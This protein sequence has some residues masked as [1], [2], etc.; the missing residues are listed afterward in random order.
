MLGVE[1]LKV[2]EPK[3]KSWSGTDSKV[4]RWRECA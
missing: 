1:T 2:R 3:L 4:T